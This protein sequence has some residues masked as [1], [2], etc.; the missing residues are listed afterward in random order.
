M[1]TFATYRNS[2]L[3]LQ[4]TVTPNT[5]TTDGSGRFEQVSSSDF[6]SGLAS[7]IIINLPVVVVVVVIVSMRTEN[8]FLV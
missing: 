8:L 3:V 5:N 1:L 6:H 4:I 2:S 7:A